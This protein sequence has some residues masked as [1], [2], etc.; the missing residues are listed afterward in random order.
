M[1]TCGRIRGFEWADVN[2][3]CLRVTV[4]DYADDIPFAEYVRRAFPSAEIREDDF[5]GKK[6]LLTVPKSERLEDV[7]AFLTLLQS[8][9][10]I[11]DDAD[12]SHA[13]GMHWYSR[14]GRTQLGELVRSTKSYGWDS[15]DPDRAS[16]LVDRA[17]EWVSR[18]PSYRR[19]SA[20]APIPPTNLQKRHD[21]PALVAKGISDALAMGMCEIRSTN[22]VEQKSLANDEHTESDAELTGA[23]T[24]ARDLTD[25]NVV[26]VDD[27]YR[28]GRTM[29][30]GVRALRA[31]GAKT[32]LSLA[33][34]K[35]SIGVDGLYAYANNWED[36]PSSQSN[37]DDINDLPFE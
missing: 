7:L 34:S 29:S 10:T 33:M 2:R 20:V 37:S 28:S 35:T 31:A 4:H 12:E 17:V 26:L 23:Y 14:H 6:F 18:H 21:L 8:S 3:R 19:A 32:V 11:D 13:L 27:L 16:E 15:G 25:Q 30:E 5:W 22:V 1:P 9:V 36:E 24:V